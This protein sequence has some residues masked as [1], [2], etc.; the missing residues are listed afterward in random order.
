MR[1]RRSSGLDPACLSAVLSVED[2]VQAWPG[3]IRAFAR[4]GMACVG[5]EV[6]ALHSLEDAARAYGVPLDA[7]MRD[8]R[9]A[10]RDGD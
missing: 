3:T 8:L 10:A 5:C 7:L 4:R 2:V 6:A 1:E 9:R